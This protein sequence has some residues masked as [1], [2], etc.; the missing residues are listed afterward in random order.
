VP[1]KVDRS[2][3]GL[4]R[5]PVNI[6]FHFDYWATVPQTQFDISPDGR[7]LA[8]TIQQVLQANIG[9]LDNIR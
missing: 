1:W 3:R 6:P 8:F 2:G 5:V 4:T 7:R 9:M